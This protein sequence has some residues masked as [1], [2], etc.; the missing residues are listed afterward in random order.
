MYLA[1]AMWYKLLKKNVHSIKNGLL[2]LDAAAL[3]GANN[4][5]KILLFNFEFLF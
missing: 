4:I 1:H 3:V 5:N 2:V